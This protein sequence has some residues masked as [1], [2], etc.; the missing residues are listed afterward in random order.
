MTH[1]D[2]DE[3]P[4]FI[5]AAM[6][7]G[8]ADLEAPVNRLTATATTAGRA[9][10]RR[11][12]FL[13]VA[14]G[15]ALVTGGVFG[16]LTLATT[17]TDDSSADATPSTSPSQTPEA[18]AWW[19]QSAAQMQRHL[20]QL[21]PRNTRV[22]TAGAGPGDGR[23]GSLAAIITNAMTGSGGLT[24]RLVAP[25]DSRRL[26]C[27]DDVRPPDTCEIT[28]GASGAPQVRQRFQTLGELQII[29]AEVEVPG[30]GQVRI[31]AANTLDEV[32]DRTA[33]PWGPEPAIALDE[34]VAIAQSPTWQDGGPPVSAPR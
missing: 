24:V 25:A 17:S 9:A 34:L 14:A 10:R 19:L 22:D 20:Q 28:V 16:G 4:G 31:A 11:R 27:P 13:A 5:A 18:T 26:T 12:T 21:L 3:D 30:G 33:R 6:R 15:A 23:S 7:R 32:W 1:D 29:T 8:V 2:P